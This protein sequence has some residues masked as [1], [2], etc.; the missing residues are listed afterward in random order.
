MGDID[1]DE[2][3]RA[4]TSLMGKSP[5]TSPPAAQPQTNEESRPT[6]TLTLGD[7]RGV[8]P[9][10]IEKAAQGIGGGVTNEETPVKSVTL[11]NQADSST[12]SAQQKP[13]ASGGKFMDV[14]HPSSNM[15]T[16]QAQTPSPLSQQSSVPATAPEDTSAKQS[17]PT[18][19]V[20]PKI[21]DITTN[22]QPQSSPAPEPQSVTVPPP[23]LAQEN[24]SQPMTLEPQSGPVFSPFLPDAKVEKRPLGGAAVASPNETPD[25]MQQLDSID[26]EQEEPHETP[27]SS[28]ASMPINGEAKTSH[29]DESDNQR[30]L[31]ASDFDRQ[32]VSPEQQL[33]QLDSIESVSSPSSPSA[34]I[35]E[36][37]P[38]QVEPVQNPG[39]WQAPAPNESPQSP[40]SDE[41]EQDQQHGIYDVNAYHQPLKHPAKEKSGWWIVIAIILV[42][43]ICASLGVAAFFVLG[44]G[45]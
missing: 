33:Q 26:T 18:T 31:N 8:T 44:P 40:V 34:A 28:I 42:I 2:L 20:S 35:V 37:A 9:D 17:S 43:I 29:E 38:P 1:F 13:Q 21:S 24:T 3:D 14:M 6:T 36:P 16:P 4:V 30:S 45:L 41:H 32:L 15:K 22:G 7:T 10:Q 23:P 11:G 5:Q 39:Q 12:T 25:S 27:D 19:P